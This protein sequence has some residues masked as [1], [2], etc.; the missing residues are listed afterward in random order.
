MFTCILLSIMLT[1]QV[2]ATGLVATNLIGFGLGIGTSVAG[3]P[4]AINIAVLAGIISAVITGS[5]LEVA[6]ADADAAVEIDIYTCMTNNFVFVFDLNDT[7]GEYLLRLY[8]DTRD[9]L[10][11]EDSIS[12]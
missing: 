6:D 4:A 12:P 3:I 9:V 11:F 2:K 1:S 8:H 5:R 7:S 10:W